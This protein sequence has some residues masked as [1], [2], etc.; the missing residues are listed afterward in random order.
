M[1]TSGDHSAY[2]ED[3]WAEVVA[4]GRPL[5][6]LSAEDFGTL[7]RHWIWANFARGW[8]FQQ[9]PLEGWPGHMADRRIFAMYLWYAMLWVLIE[10][11]TKRRVRLNGRLNA[12]LKKLR[13]PLRRGRHAL[14]HVGDTYNDE[15]F[16][17]IM[18]DPA[19]VGRIW[20]VH[21]GLGRLFLEEVRA[22]QSPQPP[23]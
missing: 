19:S 13:E 3:E 14:F 22:R 18:M 6:Q 8:Y 12:D 2:T 9:E 4:E 7:H 21:S 16:F 23:A 11:M 5:E 15:R 20:R 17:Q 10:G 1:S